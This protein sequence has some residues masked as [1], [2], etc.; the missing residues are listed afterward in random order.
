MDKYLKR[1]SKQSELGPG[2]N[3]DPDEGPSMSSGQKKAK[4]FTE[5]NMS[6]LNETSYSVKEFLITGFLRFRDQESRRTLFGVFLTVYIFVLLGN[7]LLILI[8]VSDRALHTPMY[9]LV[10]GLAILDVAITTNTV[11]SMLVLFTLEYRSVPFAACFTQTAFWLGLFGTESSLLALMAYD[12]YIA[13][14]HPLHYSNLMTNLRISKLM[15]SCLVVGFLCAIVTLALVLRLSFCGANT[16]THCFCEI[17]SLMFLTCGDNMITGYLILSIGLSV[18]FLPLVFIFFTYVRIIISVVKISSKDG[19]MKAFYTCGTHLLVI[20]VFFLGVII[21]ERI[22]VTSM[23]SRI[24]G[25]II[26]NVFP[27]LMNPVI[28]CLRTREIQSSL[29]KTLKKCRALAAGK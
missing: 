11:P 19:Q 14:C 27:A 17:T 1:K 15:A 10:C 18:S 9:I 6:S 12:R 7:I 29:A 25:L 3:C 26:Q 13:I 24:M 16:I 2:E 4:R 21:T 22:P 28:Y 20:S 23:D 8:F 5:T